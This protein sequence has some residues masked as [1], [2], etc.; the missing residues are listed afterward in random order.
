MS[1]D[2]HTRDKALVEPLRRALYD[3]EPDAVRSALARALAADASVHLA[4]PF[5]DLDGP[6]GLFDAAYVPLHAALPDL[7]RRDTIVMA[8][9]SPRGASWVGCCGYY[10]GTFMRPWLDIPPTGHQ[11]AMRFHEFFRVEDRYRREDDLVE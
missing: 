3:F 5:E 7:E 9:E 2:R 10:T 6:G 1:A 4:Y 8:G 11:V